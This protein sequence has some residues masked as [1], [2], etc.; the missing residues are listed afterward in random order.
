MY[1]F[2]ARGTVEDVLAEVPVTFHNGQESVKRELVVVER[3][4]K[5]PG[6][7]VLEFWDRDVEKLDNI[8]IGDV[9]TVLFGI[10]CISKNRSGDTRWS[11][12]LRGMDVW[13]EEM[14]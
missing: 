5:K 3:G 10:K 9:V 14:A 11:P 1:K 8:R 13:L 4:E 6:H 7:L 12:H 2:E